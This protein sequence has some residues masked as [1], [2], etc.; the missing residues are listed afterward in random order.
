M[1]RSPSLSKSPK[2]QPRLLC[3]SWIAGPAWSASSSNRPCPRFRNNI[4]GSFAGNSG[5]RFST[6]GKVC[7]A[8]MNRSGSP[9]LSRSAIPA[10]QQTKR[11]ST[12]R[13]A[14]AAHLFKVGLAHIAIQ[15]GSVALKIGFEDVE[16][17]VEIVVAHCQRPFRPAPGHLR[18]RPRRESRPL[19]GRFHHDC[20]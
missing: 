10:P 1:S 20:S 5:W 4:R 19:R 6:S 2:A 15:I 11:F 14:L 12:A 17:A 7:P 16:A 8:T 13:P 3:D 9:S 18:R